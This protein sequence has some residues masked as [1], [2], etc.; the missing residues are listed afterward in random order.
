MKKITWT[1]IFL[2]I[3]TVLNVL[4]GT[5]VIPPVSGTPVCPSVVVSA[6]PLPVHALAPSA[7]VDDAGLV[8][9]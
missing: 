3:S 4:G 5:S 2:I 1:Q 7:D 6:A 9:K 8:T